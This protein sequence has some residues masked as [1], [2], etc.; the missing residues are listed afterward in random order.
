[1]S[2]C[3]LYETVVE[4]KTEEFSRDSWIGGGSRSNGVSDEK[5]GCRTRTGVEIKREV[6]GGSEKTRYKQKEI[7][8]T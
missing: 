4:E 2:V 5:L 6:G 7:K 8:K 1:M 3:Y